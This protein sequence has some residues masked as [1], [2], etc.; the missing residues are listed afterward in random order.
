M[1]NSIAVRASQM[2]DT[3][4]SGLHRATRGDREVV[5]RPLRGAWPTLAAMEARTPVYAAKCYCPGV[6]EAAVAMATRRA[7]LDDRASR[8][9]NADCVGAIF[10]PLDDLVLC[11]FTADSPG[12]VRQASERAGM[13][14]E[15]VMEAVWLPARSTRKG[16]VDENP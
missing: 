1:R 13:P 4:A 11:V 6:S 9:R 7:V 8:A 5:E 14:C 12:D 2:R 3:P 16:S 10:F 15:R